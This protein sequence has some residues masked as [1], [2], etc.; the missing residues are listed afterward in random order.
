MNKINVAQH[1]KR[2]Y[3]MR[4][5]CP[6]VCLSVCR[7]TCIRQR[8]PLSIMILGPG[9]IVSIHGSITRCT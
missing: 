5:R 1:V 9:L 6:Y 2:C 3:I 4:R 8:A 7:L